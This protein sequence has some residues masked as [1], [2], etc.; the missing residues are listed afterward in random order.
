[1]KKILIVEDEI[2]YTNLLIDQLTSKGYQVIKASNGAQ[3]LEFAKTENPDLI[4]LDIKMPKMDGLTMLHLLR[5]D[6]N[7]KHAKV[8]MLTNLE[9]DENIIENVIK[10]QPTYY[11]VKS[12]VKFTDLLEK[13]KY[14]LN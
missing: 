5:N 6:T 2:S 7:Y 12:D 11:Y 1:M 4:L 9:P 13:I 14:L 3:G 10:D 8:I